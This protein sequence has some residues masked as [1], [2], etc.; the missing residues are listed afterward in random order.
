MVAHVLDSNTLWQ[1]ES[2]STVAGDDVLAVKPND[3]PSAGRWMRMPGAALLRLPFYAT[4]PSGTNLL[5][6]PSGSI[7]APKEFGVAVSRVF[8]GASN[9]A[10]AVSSSNHPGHTGVG[11]FMGSCVAT[12]LNN[13]FTG[14]GSTF[15]MGPI[16]SGTFDSFANRRTWMKGGDTIRLD[17]IGAQFGTGVGAILVECDILQNPGV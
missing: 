15:L 8:T 4:T 5:T 2:A 9:A 1:Y 17:V 11:G 10:I 13:A 16:A 6:V 3:N 14:T 7:L 12:Q